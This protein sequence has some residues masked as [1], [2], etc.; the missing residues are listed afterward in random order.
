M[1]SGGEG[2]GEEALPGH[3]QPPSHPLLSAPYNMF[4]AVHTHPAQWLCFPTIAFVSICGHI[5]WE[6]SQLI[7]IWDFYV[8]ALGLLPLKNIQDGTIQ[9]NFLK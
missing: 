7:Q 2:A 6:Q 8:S 9:P 3:H 1:D 4:P 5:L